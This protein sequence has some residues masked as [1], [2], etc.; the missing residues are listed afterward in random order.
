MSDSRES[1]LSEDSVETEVEKEGLFSFPFYGK[2]NGESADYTAEDEVKA[3]VKTSKEPFQ[4]TR[5]DSGAGRYYR[6]SVGG[7]TY[8]LPSV[9]SVLL[10]PGQLLWPVSLAEVHDQGT[11]GGGLPEAAH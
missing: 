2:C 7:E 8:D 9:T 10:V 1:S 5:V 6:I 4:A 3:Q 11:R